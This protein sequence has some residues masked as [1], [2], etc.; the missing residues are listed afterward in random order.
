MP[1]KLLESF[2]SG[3]FKIPSYEENKKK[4]CCEPHPQ[5]PTCNC[6]HPLPSPCPTHNSCELI[7]GNSLEVDVSKDDCEVRADLEVARKKIVRLWGQIKDCDGL[8]VEGASVKLLKQITT[9]GKP[10]YVGVAH[11]ITDCL[12]FYQFDLC[13]CQTPAKYRIVVGKAAVGTERVVE[14]LGSCKPCNSNPCH[15]K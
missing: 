1:N 11:A 3:D 13:P 4:P 14:S 2:Y 6:Q 8:P 7:I 5:N 10:N 12:G 9:C 15:C